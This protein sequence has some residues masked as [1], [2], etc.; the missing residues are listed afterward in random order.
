MLDHRID[1]P[2]GESDPKLSSYAARL[3]EL[4]ER[5]SGAAGGTHR[6]LEGL[7][8]F[9][10]AKGAANTSAYFL[11]AGWMMALLRDTAHKMSNDPPRRDF[12]EEVPQFRRDLLGDLGPE[13]RSDFESLAADVARESGSAA[14]TLTAHLEAFEKWQGAAGAGDAR[15]SDLQWRTAAAFARGAGRQCIRLQVPYDRLYDV[16]NLGDVPVLGVEVSDVGFMTDWPDRLLAGCFLA[17]VPRSYVMAA[18]SEPRD[19]SVQAAAFR[20]FGAEVAAF[21]REL[22]SDFDSSRLPTRV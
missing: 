19:S 2:R 1:S 14:Q 3:R 15:W 17:G 13:P 7:A 16:I 21:G 10:A 6:A 8:L 9:E 22:I 18:S 20:D 5:T 11:F 4:A 12:D